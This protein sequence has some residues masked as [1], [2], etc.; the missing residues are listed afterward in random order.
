MT[1]TLD[2]DA[3]STDPHI[4]R[5]LSDISLAVAKG[6]KIVVV[7]GAGISC[8]CGIPDFRSS[9]GLYALVKEQYPDVVLKGR[10]LF[11]ASLFR[12]ATSTAVFYTFISQLKRSIDS[13]EP[14]PTHHFIKTL[15]TKKKLLRSYTQNIDGLE[16]RVGLLGSSCQ[17]AKSNGK[18]TTKIRTKDVRNVQ[19]HGDIHRVRC[20][21]CS[22]EY[23]CNEEHLIVFEKGSAPE[24]PECL[25]RSEARV[26]RAARAIR[27]GNLRPGIV[28]Y[29]ETHPL[30]DDIGT[31]HT[32]DLGRKPDM[33]I[34]MGTSLKVH[35]LKKLVKDFARTIHSSSSPSSAASSSKRPYKVIFVNKTAPGS[36]WS[37]IIDYHIGGETDRW[38]TKVVED[39][40]KMRPSDWEVQQTLVSGEAETSTN[41]GLKV[42][43]SLVP[44]KGG[45]GPR[46][47]ENIPVLPSHSTNEAFVAGEKPIPLSPSKRRQKSSHYDN[48][49]SSP[50]KRQTTASHYHGMPK[51]ERKMLFAETTNKPTAYVSD[52]RE[53][54]KMDIS[55]YDLTMEDV[56]GEL[57]VRPRKLSTKGRRVAAVEET[58][59]MDISI[60]DLSMRHQESSVEIKSP[61]RQSKKAQPKVPEKPRRT[62]AKRGTKEKRTAKKELVH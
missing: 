5:T 61:I 53:K 7:T 1:V 9:D 25:S 34:I 28:L 38:T 3:A 51:E 37:D 47:R 46:G 16:A 36:E 45:K 13:A 58:S 14:T 52:T 31:I 2:L 6:K 43:K 50:S 12:D 59:K 10:D 29:D 19:L 44:T 41:G 24:C 20:M 22:A 30:G 26:A 4:R 55:L 42:V 27:V 33:L 18:G 32:A 15:D 17:E 8:S 60:L 56:E 35:G 62:T 54:S 11:D 48:V 23:P 49:E 39:W 21:A 57:P 40:K